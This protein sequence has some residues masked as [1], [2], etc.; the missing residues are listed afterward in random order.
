M[1]GAVPGHRFG[2]LSQP[3]NV[4]FSGS[5]RAS[6]DGQAGGSAGVAEGGAQKPELAAYTNVTTGSASVTV[7]GA[8]FRASG[9]TFENAFDERAHPEMANRQA[10]AVKT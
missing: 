4:G 1:G 8:D 2:T 6:R 10:V 3:R 9:I 7:A 5:G